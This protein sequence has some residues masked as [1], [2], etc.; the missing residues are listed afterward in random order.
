MTKSRVGTITLIGSGEF[1]ESMSRV[2]RKALAS[3]EGA[4][5]ALFLDTP[6]GFELNVDEIS[7]KAVDYFSQRF[8]IS[9]DVASFKNKAR[10]GAADVATALGKL[11]H[12]NFILAGPGSPSYAVH[13]WR[14]TV[15]WDTVLNRW[16][17]GAALVLASAAAI[18][19]GA[20]TL[21]VYE[22]YKAGHDPHWMSGL[23][24]FERIGLNLAIVPHW[25]NSEG[26]T[27][28]TRYCYIGAP[29][30]ELLK[31]QLP[32]ETVIL[33]IDEYTACFF[34]PNTQHCEIMGAGKVTVQHG[35]DS[36]DYPAGTSFGFEELRRMVR[37]TQSGGERTARGPRAAE[38][39]PDPGV[40]STETTDYLHQLAVALSETRESE[41][42]R[43]L[44]EQAH[45][46]MH[47][48]SAEWMPAHGATLA[49]DGSPFLDMLVELR[50]Q[51]R[52]A[53]QYG[54]ADEVR[55]KLSQLGIT[56]EDTPGGT[57]WKRA[58]E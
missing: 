36:R 5:N 6:A 58:E 40:V 49:Q 18:T 16:L 3:L 31:A 54:L 52:G 21:P 12:A 27:F 1:A 20:W 14:A 15:V 23:N 56:L 10:A 22:I 7:A 34:D 32:T 37:A 19:T 33:G 43:D 39:G 8:S 42:Q 2:H 9:L 35:A 57:R 53:K 11:R 38:A 29:R 26:G 45:D 25:N 47:E 48:L 44:I 17:D 46:T 55:Q 4:V 13:N 24:L 50:T 51:L 41:R 30:F 28:D